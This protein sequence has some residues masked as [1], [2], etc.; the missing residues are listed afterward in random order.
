MVNIP[1]MGPSSQHLDR[2]VSEFI[3][4]DFAQ[5]RESM[6]VRE[7]LDAVR[8]EGIGE[9]IVYFYVVGESER[10]VGV[11]PT[12]RL[13]TATLDQRIGDLMIKRIVAI[14]RTATLLEA[15][16]FFVL[17]KFFAFPVVDEERRILGLIDIGVF[18]DE[19]FDIAERE[20]Y[21]DVF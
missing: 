10:L 6:T 9:K 17:H 11:L 19:V 16:E 18:T 20:R 2:P 7:A 5:L 15:C 1:A 21:G 13:L 3:R 8:K 14:P 4:K 12:R